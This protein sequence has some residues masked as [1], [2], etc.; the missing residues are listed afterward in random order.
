MIKIVSQLVSLGRSGFLSNWEARASGLGGALTAAAT[1]VVVVWI[2]RRVFLFP[3]CVF[4]PRG[5]DHLR[6]CLRFR[7]V[8]TER[9]EANCLVVS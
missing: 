1:V 5:S 7:S 8:D 4:F 3:T 2:V 6:G 9:Y